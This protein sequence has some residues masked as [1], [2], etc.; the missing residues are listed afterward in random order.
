MP[1]PAFESSGWL[2]AGRHKAT[3]SEVEKHLDGPMLSKR[4]QLLQALLHWKDELRRLGV[5]GFIVLDGSFVSTK[6]EPG[7]IDALVVYDKRSER[8]LEESSEA[9]ELLDLIHCK[10]RGLGDI[11]MLSAEA[12]GKFPHLC[13]L[14]GFDFDKATKVRKG[15]LEV[16]I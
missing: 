7:D 16:E 4:H 2:P 9:R 14:D 15:V 11:F 13:R 3:W 12:I 6:H 10:V 8:I 5:S 1:I